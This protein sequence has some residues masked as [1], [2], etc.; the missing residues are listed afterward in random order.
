VSGKISGVSSPPPSAPPSG[1]GTRA[2]ATSSQAPSGTSDTDSVQITETASHLVVAEQA[3][4]E[5]PVISQERVTVIS[6]ALAAGLYKI[7]PERIAN[8][9]LQIERQLPEDP[10]E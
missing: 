4:T 3:L 7:S 9:L 2:A 5:V 6:D 10:A 8:K 1:A